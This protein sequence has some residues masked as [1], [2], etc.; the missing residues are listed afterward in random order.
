MM[1]HAKYQALKSQGQ[2]N[3]WCIKNRSNDKNQE[4]Y[5][6]T[7]SF[8]GHLVVNNRN[9]LVVISGFKGKRKLRIIC[10][11]NVLFLSMNAFTSS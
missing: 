4:N 3:C 2:G 5:S 8:Q 9:F 11:Q 7:P 1:E 6:S 10:I